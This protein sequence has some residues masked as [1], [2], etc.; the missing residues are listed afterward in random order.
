MNFKLMNFYKFDKIKILIN[1]NL[2]KSSFVNVNFANFE[3]HSLNFNPFRLIKNSFLK[4][5]PSFIYH[6]YFSCLTD[7][8][9]YFWVIFLN[10][11]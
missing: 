1:F 6:F 4:F 10:M 8:Y 5:Y 9:Y 11:I 7:P 2:N 3:F